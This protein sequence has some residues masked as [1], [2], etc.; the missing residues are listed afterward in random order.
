[1]DVWVNG[2][3]IHTAGEFTEDG[4]ETHFEIKGHPSK[5]RSVSSGKKKLGIVHA[6]FVDGNQQNCEGSSVDYRLAGGQ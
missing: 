4:T 5:I 2:H 1:M 3:K 6:L